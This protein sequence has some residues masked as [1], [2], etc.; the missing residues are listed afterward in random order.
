MAYSDDPS[1]F[2]QILVCYDSYGAV[3]R[4]CVF[5]CFKMYYVSLN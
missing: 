5:V 3:T 1:N 2:K 4:V